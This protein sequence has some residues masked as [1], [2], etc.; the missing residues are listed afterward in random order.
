MKFEEGDEEERVTV[1]SD[2][3][4]EGSVEPNNNPN[5]RSGDPE[6]GHR[7]VDHQENLRTSGDDERDIPSSPTE[8]LAP[9]SS[10][11]NPPTTHTPTSQSP[12]PPT[13]TPTIRRSTRANKGV[14]P[15]HPDEDPKLQ[16]GSRPPT[17]K[18]STLA[19]QQDTLTSGGTSAD[20]TNTGG[21][22]PDGDKDGGAL[23]LTV[24]MPCSY[25]EAMG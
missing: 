19:V 17:K 18:P 1:D 5:T 3:E 8:L 15:T 11:P 6:G 2:S 16:L 10:Y 12:N 25:Q 7:P 20:T 4:G 23:F 24:D 21:T 13:I 22:L 9:T 14:P